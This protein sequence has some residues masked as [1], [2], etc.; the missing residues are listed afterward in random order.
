[1]DH[2]YY[3]CPHDPRNPR[4]PA[5]APDHPATVSVREDVLTE[6]IRQFFAARIFGPDR[7]TLLAGQL[8]AGAAEDAARREKATARLRKRLK[9][10]DAT[11]DAHV[12]EVQALAGMDPNSP[13][14]TAMRTRH[15]KRFTELEAEREDISRT[16]A[17]LAR[18]AAQDRPAETRPC[19]TGYPCSATSWRAPRTGSSRS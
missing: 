1:M 17:A 13:A 4:H 3:L 8:P 14:V 9:Q 18:Q 5:Q 10:I 16:L 15:L 19:W 11:E 6:Q 7:A 2:V 12:R